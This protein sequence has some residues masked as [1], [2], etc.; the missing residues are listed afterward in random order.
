MDQNLLARARAWIASD[1]DPR[2]RAELAA[3]LDAA[4]LES[5]ASA[6]LE[7]ADRLDGRLAFGTAGIRG[8]VAAGSN[9]INLAVVRQTAWALAQVLIGRPSAASSTVIVGNDARPDSPAFAADMAATLA[10]AGL[11]V[12]CFEAPV[13]TPIVAFHARAVGAAAA[14]VVTA[15]H[16]PRADN[17]IKVYDDHGVQIVGPWDTM[18]SAAI[19]DTPAAV[20]IMQDQARVRH[21]GAEVEAAYRQA[22]VSRLPTVRPTSSVVVVA[23]ALHGVGAGP[24]TRLLG[25]AGHR[26]EHVAAQEQ[27]DGTFPTLAFPNP[28]EPG[29][30]DLALDLARRRGADI[31]LA[32]DPDADRLAVALPDGQGGHAPL[33]GNDVGVL[34]A[35]ALLQERAGQSTSARLV[36]ASSIV[37]SP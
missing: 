10:A 21:L 19:A 22:L 25:D 9:R 37:S 16:N 5:G 30:L 17:G 12:W 20:D 32:N 13:P 33:T 35:D 24:L 34:L 3:L 6:A 1:P 15:S 23:T 11:D 7:L 14:V 28:E 4:Q 29:A 26:V 8:E 31:V 18:I 2:T 36:V 27:P